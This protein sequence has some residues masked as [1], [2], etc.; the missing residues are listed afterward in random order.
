MQFQDSALQ[1]GATGGTPASAGA[2]EFSEGPS[3]ASAMGISSIAAT[4]FGD[5]KVIRRNGSVVAFEPSNCGVADQAFIGAWWPGSGS[6]S[7]SRAGR[8]MPIAL[9]ER[10]R[11]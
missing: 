1:T 9:C 10:C 4:S 2:H 3:N 8:E 11:R 6:G 5:Y 7:H